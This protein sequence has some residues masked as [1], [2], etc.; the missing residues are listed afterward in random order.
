M[1]GTKKN[2]KRN[3]KPKKVG[4]I[5]CQYCGVKRNIKCRGFCSGIA[6]TECDSCGRVVT[7]RKE[8]IG[9]QGDFASR[10]ERDKRNCP[11]THS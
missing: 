4:R 11:L 2:K 10:E 6:L 1:A 8:C 3:R 7:G 9:C 5:Q